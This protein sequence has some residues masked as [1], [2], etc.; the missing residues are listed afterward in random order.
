MNEK[1]L[2]ADA[3]AV[4]SAERIAA[5]QLSHAEPHAYCH[6]LVCS[7]DR[8]YPRGAKNV[9]CSCLGRDTVRAELAAVLNTLKGACDREWSDETPT[10]I[11]TIVANA[12]YWRDREIQR[13]T[14]V[15]DSV[16][17]DVRD[18]LDALY[19]MRGNDDQSLS[20]ASGSVPSA[21]QK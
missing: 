9:T 17:R 11:A 2:G 1:P 3:A 16:K 4:E 6:D 19:Q 21:A 7:A 10:Q 12:I 15:I 18:T 13:L 14:D 5:D 20:E 8:R